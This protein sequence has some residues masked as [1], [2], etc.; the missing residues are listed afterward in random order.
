MSRLTRFFF[1]L[2]A[3]TV[4]SAASAADILDLPYERLEM[5]PFMKSGTLVFSDCPEYAETHGILAEG[6]VA[7]DGR[8]YYYHV[9][10]TGAPARLVLY[11]ESAKAATLDIVKTLRG[12]PSLDYVTSGRSLSFA[13]AVSTRETPRTVSLPAGKRVILA[14]EP[15]NLLPGYLYTGILE[16]RTKIPVRVG[17]ALLPMGTDEETETA[18]TNAQPVPA[19]SHEMRGTFP[20]TVL[21]E[22]ERKWNPEKDGP[23]EILYGSGEGNDFFTGPD[24]LDGVVRENTG[25]YGISVTLRVNT[26]GSGKFRLYFNPQGGVYLGTFTVR[27]GYSPK[28]FR[29]DDMKYRGRPIGYETENDYIEAGEW[30]AGKPLVIEFMPAGATYLPVRFLFVPKEKNNA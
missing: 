2:L 12:A 26:E 1:F 11:A 21:L 14:E 4:V 25:N 15:E 28:Y 20:M 17:T 3:I 24:E 7:G 23:A 22:N 27:Q 8:V 19:D 16:C 9:N 18:L 30:E 13:E 29:T 10:S 6:T 5:K